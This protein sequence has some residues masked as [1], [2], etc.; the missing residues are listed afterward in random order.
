MEQQFDR[1]ISILWCH[2]NYICRYLQIDRYLNAEMLTLSSWCVWH[3]IHNLF[4]VKEMGVMFMSLSS[5][6][7]SLETL[8]N[9]RH[10]FST[11]QKLKKSFIFLKIPLRIHYSGSQVN[12]SYLCIMHKVFG[13]G[14]EGSTCGNSSLLIAL[15]MK[16]LF[17]HYNRVVMFLI[18]VPLLLF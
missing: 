1:Q 8:F 11:F 9:P 14:D 6:N 15:L 4:S 18:S 2:N 10:T 13:F 17:R 5:V 7:E 12:R 3:F 16:H